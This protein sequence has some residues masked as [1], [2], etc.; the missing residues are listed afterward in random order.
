MSAESVSVADIFTEMIRLAEIM[1]A[2]TGHVGEG[3]FGMNYSYR[4]GPD[5]WPTDDA[6]LRCGCG[7]ILQSFVKGDGE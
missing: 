3:H 5:G 1:K 2:Q 6:D 7:D 4:K